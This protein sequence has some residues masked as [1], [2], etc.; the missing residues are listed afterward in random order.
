MK[1]SKEKLIS[2]I[3]ILLIICICSF[4]IAKY[5]VRMNI[6]RNDIPIDTSVRM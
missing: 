2:Y 1:L 3:S 5:I 4:L 6:D